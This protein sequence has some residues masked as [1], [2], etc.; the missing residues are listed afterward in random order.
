MMTAR[1]RFMV[2][3]GGVALVVAAVLDSAP[4]FALQ[5]THGVASGDVT[6]F[7]V[8]LWTRVDGPA[9]LRVEVERVSP[10]SGP[11][12]LERLAAVTAESDFTVRVLVAPL[13]PDATYAYRFRGAGVTSETGSFQTPP[14]P[15]IQRSLR[16]AYS[17]DSDGTKIGGV[18]FFSN[19]E[20]LD[21]ARR[22]GLDFF[23]YH[24]DMI[25]PDS[26]IRA[27]RGQGPSMTLQEYRDTYKEN[28]E[29]P[30][31]RDLLAA[32]S[33][34]VAWDDHEVQNDYDGQTVDPVRYANGRRAFHEFMPTL[35]IPFPLDP[36]CAG[37]PRFRV[38]PWGSE[39]DVIL[40]DER[41]CR[42]ADVAAECQGD[43]APTLPGFLRIAFGLP[44]SPPPGCLPAIFDP[45]RTMLGP[46]QKELL[47]RALLHSRARFKFVLGGLP[48]QQYWTLP[49]DRWEGYGAE[50][51]EILNFIRDNDIKNVVF[52]AT[53]SHAN[54]TNEVVVDT[55]TDPHPIAR[56]FVTG[57]I[58][59]STL[60][61]EIL[62]SGGP[63]ALAGFNIVLTFAG[64]D[65]RNLNEY[66]Y[67]L[68][69][70]DATA[71]TARVAFKDA[72]GSA[73][74]D[75]FT[76]LPCGGMVGP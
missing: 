70:V 11:K 36:V 4:S 10:G 35:E 6:P 43:P 66:S 16:F 65:C 63:A 7:S 62:A 20:A 47:K 61:Q 29:I 27:L 73:V 64:V 9:M 15:W 71:R 52:L 44:A 50:R 1:T 12:M 60:E 33:V 18:P 58:A 59:T 22:E 23:V 45:S 21:A 3:A 17:G 31:L 40:I 19:F 32:T 8:V 51:N 72:N 41:S 2:L 48:I 49:Y 69:E 57:P 67:A 26:S 74:L 30:A 34:Y 68:V 46:V 24:G 53:D 55:V 76:N 56:E 25:Y 38:F 14:L 75:T 39:A 13:V 37:P 54:F 42:S 5:F 28:R